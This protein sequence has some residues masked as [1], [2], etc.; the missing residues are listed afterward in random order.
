LLAGCAHGPEAVPE[1][2]HPSLPLDVAAVAAALTTPGV[3]AFSLMV[4]GQAAL[5]YV[6]VPASGTSDKLVVICHGFG[7]AAKD[8]QDVLKGLA[9]GGVLAVAMD[10]RG[11]QDAWKVRA[12]VNDTLAVTRA[13]Q[14]LHPHLN[15]TILYG[16]SMG[17]EVSG[18]AVAEA[19]PGTFDFWFDGAGV[20]DL[21]AMWMQAPPFRPAIERET[22]GPP[23]AVPEAYRTRSP[24]ML[25]DRIAEAGLRRAYLVY[26]PADTI[27]PA[28]HGESMFRAL[29]DA[30]VAV[31][32]YAV[33][34]DLDTYACVPVTLDC[35]A[36]PAGPASHEAGGPRIVLPLVQERLDGKPDPADPAVRG[37][38]D[39]I[40]LTHWP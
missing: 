22:G 12:G 5:G 33:T 18:M 17:G 11:A 36:L 19:P 27:V 28:D 37:V 35:A 16:W 14:A 26:A 30:G 8:W 1:P 4:D 10:Y 31:T 20:T 13:L 24:A 23:D 40:T 39:G 15:M 3:R 21:P 29:Q 6:G 7:G 2:E 25:G 34:S 9:D 32:H 38:Y